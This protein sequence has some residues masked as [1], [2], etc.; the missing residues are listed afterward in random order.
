MV[1]ELELTDL[2]EQYSTLELSDKRRELGKEIT[3]T[4]IVLKKL[5]DDSDMNANLEY[6][7][8]D[9]YTNLYQTTTSEDEYLT[10]LYEDI[11]NMKE[12][13]AI[14]LSKF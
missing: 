5:I 10:G 13:L 6:D 4:M 8:L 14:Y 1:E 9:E 11:M 2:V 3:E 12:L 7:K